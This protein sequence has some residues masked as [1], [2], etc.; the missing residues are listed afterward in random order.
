[1][2]A[3][4]QPTRTAHLIRSDA[5]AIAV[6]RTL[7]ERFAVEASVRDRERRPPFAELDEFSASGLWGITIPKAYGGAGASC[8]T[9]AQVIKIISAADS[10]LGQL[11]QNHLGVL[12]ILL[13]TASEEQKRYYF[14][15]VLQGYRFG[16]AFSEAGSKH[17]GAF[18][19]RIRFNA[20]GARIEVAAALQERAQSLLAR[21][22]DVAE[23]GVAQAEAAIA[24]REALLAVSNA[25]F[26]LTGQRSPLPAALD[27]P[28]RWKYPLIGNYRLNGV[29]PPSFRSAV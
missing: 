11:P 5:E 21:E 28:L 3:T 13:Q 1:M 15:K 22:P 17:A 23:I 14:A 7:A 16:N 9:V 19:T 29:V 25:E 20:D 6:A 10:S 24:S 12:D 27:E 8:V 2:T 4:A 26:E 18:E